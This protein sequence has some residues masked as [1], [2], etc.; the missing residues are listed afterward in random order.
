M[1]EKIINQRLYIVYLIPILIGSLSVLSFQPF[2]F[3][4]INFLTIPSLFLTLTYI[5]KKSKSNYRKKPYLKNLFLA[6]YFFGFGFFLFGN[7]WISYSL[8]FDES[9]KFLIPFSLIL[10]PMFLALFYGFASM[11]A[12][13]FIKNNYSSILFFCV[14]FSFS[15]YLRSK[16]L[17]GFP[18][19]LWAYSWSW[20]TEILQ[21]LNPI[22]LF[23][24][25]F[26]SINF[27]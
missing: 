2:N 7:Y 14:I 23:A 11:I 18:W 17:S 22:G 26:L 4:V 15:D 27:F 21:I 9:F 10:L 20:F 3:S 12:G 24:F 1:L 5:S 6:G 8:T 25:N 13:I 19:N 16:I